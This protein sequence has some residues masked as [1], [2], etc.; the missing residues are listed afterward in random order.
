VRV[1]DAA[2]RI[3]GALLIRGQAKRSNSE[4]RHSGGDQRV[5][6]LAANAVSVTTIVLNRQGRDK[7]G[8]DGGE[9]ARNP[10]GPRLRVIAGSI[11]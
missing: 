9:S 11:T 4:S 2:R 3:S 5:R 1:P 6:S 7:P 10:S 8:H